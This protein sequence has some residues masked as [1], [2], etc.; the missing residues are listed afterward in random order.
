LDLYNSEL[1][2]ASSPVLFWNLCVQS[3]IWISI[4]ICGLAAVVGQGSKAPLSLFL[5]DSCHLCK[6]SF[7]TSLSPPPP[8]SVPTL[9]CV[10][11]FTKKI[12]TLLQER[13]HKKDLSLLC[14]VTSRFMLSS[15]K[16]LPVIIFYF[17]KTDHFVSQKLVFF[18]K[19]LC[20]IWAICSIWYFKN[21]I[22]HNFLKNM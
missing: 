12:C 9:D 2:L 3:E 15:E 6:S 21:T 7:S 19:A 4:V 18:H 20:K 10:H 1:A 8:H 16:G 11:N 14:Q 17:N 13:S 22:I 5:R